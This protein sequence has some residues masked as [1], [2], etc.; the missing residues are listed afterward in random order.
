MRLA[1]M[2]FMVG[3]V[4]AGPLQASGEDRA[5]E[6]RNLAAVVQMA[7]AS[8]QPASTSSPGSQPSPKPS[9][10]QVEMRECKIKGIRAVASSQALSGKPGVEIE[11]TSENPFPVRNALVLL[12]IGDEYFSPGTY[13]TGDLHTLVFTLTRE[14]FDRLRSGVGVALGYG[15]KT[16]FYEGEPRWNGGPLDKSLLKDSGSQPPGQQPAVKTLPVKFDVYGGYFVSNKFEPQAP[17]SFVVLQDQKAFDEVFG[18][19]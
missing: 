1:L 3:F 18:I 16:G 7:A 19:A 13:P 14:E 11:L 5:G 12:R 9:T 17:A 15:T 4:L 10:S 8:P 2:A 6:G